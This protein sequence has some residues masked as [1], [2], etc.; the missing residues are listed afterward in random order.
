MG[1]LNYNRTYNKINK[2]RLLL[3]I[4]HS[5]PGHRISSGKVKGCGIEGKDRKGGSCK[6]R[7]GGGGM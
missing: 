7:E 5:Y 3:Y 1:F 2:Q 4:Y 6:E